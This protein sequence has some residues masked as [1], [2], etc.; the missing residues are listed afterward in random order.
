MAASSSLTTLR[1][2]IFFICDWNVC[3]L[4]I[5]YKSTSKSNLCEK[6]RRWLPFF[7]FFIHI[8]FSLFFFFF[9]G[10]FVPSLNSKS[11]PTSHV[12]LSDSRFLSFSKKISHLP[13]NGKFSAFSFKNKE[14]IETEKIKRI[15]AGQGESRFLISLKAHEEVKVYN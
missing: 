14:M 9:S 15:P 7:I 8:I 13:T 1:T 2:P 6:S 12:F 11:A 5:I 4:G 3:G 10:P